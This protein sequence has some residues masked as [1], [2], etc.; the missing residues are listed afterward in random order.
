[1]K[2]FVKGMLLC[3]ALLM[4]FSFSAEAKARINKKSAT[5][6]VGQTVRLK[7]KGT[8]KKVKWRSS[9]K[10]IASV[11]SKGKVSGK[12]EGRCIITAKVGKK[13]L[14][15]VITIERKSVRVYLSSLKAYRAEG[16]MYRYDNRAKE[17]IFGTVYYHYIAS[18][19]NGNFTKA[20]CTYRIDGKY[21][22]MTG[23]FFVPTSNAKV[24]R[25]V[26]ITGDNNILYENYVKGGSDSLYFSIDLTGVKD[27]TLEMHGDV[28]W[29]TYLG[30]PLLVG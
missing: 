9:N 19:G 15:C 8:K 10:R 20:S 24:K 1:M 11:N 17:D 23:T 29:G 6:Y 22:S 16:L 12:S 4:M 28:G 21:K 27:L 26:C 13:I 30:D 25:Y 14:K 5:L 3:I 7:V 2:R 18:N